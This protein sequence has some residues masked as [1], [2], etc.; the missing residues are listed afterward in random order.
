[1]PCPSDK[2]IFSVSQL[3]RQA[4]QLLETALPLIWVSG[5]LSNISRPSSGHWYFTLKD[6]RAQVRCAMFRN[7]NQ[8][9][10]WQPSAGKQVVIRARV[11]LYE[12]RGDYQLI[13]E[14]L[15][16]AGQGDLQQ[17]YNALK[18][19]LQ[20]EGL[21]AEERKQALPRYVRTLGII[22]SPSGAAVQDIISVLKRRYPMAHLVI[23][24]V[25]V[26]GERAAPA[27]VAALQQAQRKAI[28]DLLI[29]GRGGG[30]IEDL[31]AYNDEALVR[32][33]AQ[34]T[35]PV[36]S[37]VGHETDFTLCDFV[38]DVRA[39]TPSA[40]AEI[41]TPDSNEW[42]QTLDGLQQQFIRRLRGLLQTKADK[43]LAL[44]QR[45]RHPGEKIRHRQQG[46]Q[47]HR[48]ALLQLMQQTLASRQQV[49]SS[50]QQ[51]LAQQHPRRV[52]R[53]LTAQLEQ[54]HQR[55]CR[56]MHQLL[57]SKQQQLATQGQLLQSI[58]PLT[59]LSRGYAVVSDA[60]GNI[61]YSS[62]QVEAGS[63]L[64]IQLGE[65]RLATRVV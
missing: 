7:A 24:P 51:R 60:T 29:I 18:D 42:R 40:S 37:A 45:L 15:E 46:L 10:R 59:V 44:K 19:K 8:R 50:Y 53:A 25:P 33:I 20:R 23:L 64:T 21:F 63:L 52:T 17:A 2:I 26:Q 35:I 62:Q 65:G 38:A 12:G 14:H 43:L 47:Q 48:R 27:M 3:N 13:A 32:A 6:D 54:L 41:A 36:I 30:A 34:C 55:H 16:D 61:I 4:K 9:I 56:A 57:L 49:L 22:T 1:M 39:P 11:S 28:V 58:S 5:E 31:W